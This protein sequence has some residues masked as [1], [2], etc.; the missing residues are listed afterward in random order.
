MVHSV[1]TSEPLHTYPAPLDMLSAA[2]R[3]GFSWPPYPRGFFPGP[4]TET[5]FL[6]CSPLSY[7][8][9]VRVAACLRDDTDLLSSHPPWHGSE[10][11]QVTRKATPSRVLGTFPAVAT[12]FQRCHVDVTSC[13]VT[14]SCRLC[15][16]KRDGAFRDSRKIQDIPIFA[17]QLVAPILFFINSTPVIAFK[18]IL[19]KFI[20]QS[21]SIHIFLCTL[22]YCY[23]S[24]EILKHLYCAL[25]YTLR[26]KKSIWK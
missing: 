24:N 11:W 4:L 23:I 9:N 19:Y 15:Q 5:C 2:G 22:I 10:N 18:Q 21:P 17:D 6:F 13:H 12:S 14:L 20:R 1:G 7:D 8:A 26:K 25:Q 16:R 3:V